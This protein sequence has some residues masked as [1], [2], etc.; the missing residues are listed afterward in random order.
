MKNVGNP[1]FGV[2]CL[3]SQVLPLL[4]EMADLLKIAFGPNGEAVMIQQKSPKETKVTKVS[5]FF[6]C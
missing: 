5:V 4:K 3:K 2:I 6:C 1:N